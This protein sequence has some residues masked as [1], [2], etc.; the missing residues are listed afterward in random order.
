MITWKPYPDPRNGEYAESDGLV[1]TAGHDGS[2][3]VWKPADIR[4]WDAL[5]DGDPGKHA[6]S[7][8]PMASA[9]LVRNASKTLEEAKA[10]AE[11]AYHQ[12]I[13]VK[14]HA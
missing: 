8:A 12:M 9:D 13:K 7:I 5:L 2:W 11:L 1:L 3:A 10:A 6:P 4:A 14:I